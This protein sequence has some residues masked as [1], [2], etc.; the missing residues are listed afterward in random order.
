[1]DFLTEQYKNRLLEL[2]GI[3]HSN[4]PEFFYHGSNRLFDKFDL[5]EMGKNFSSSILGIYFTQYLKPTPFGSTAKEY[6][7]EL[8]RREGGKPYI[9][10]CKINYKNPLMLNSNG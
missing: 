4:L 9:Y 5:K 8:V 1:M 10:K 7:E 2:A 6:A 3:N